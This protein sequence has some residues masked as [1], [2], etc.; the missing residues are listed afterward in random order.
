VSK[1]EFR[2][3]RHVSSAA[4][5]EGDRRQTA[6]TLRN[7]PSV[8]VRCSACAATYTDEQ[9]RLLQ[10]G[11]QVSDQEVRRNVRFWPR[12]VVIEVRRCSRCGHLIPAKRRTT[13]SP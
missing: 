3:R 4:L 10:V 12:E 11:P 9:W 1:D 13:T 8:E 7:E 2:L 6:M 5:D